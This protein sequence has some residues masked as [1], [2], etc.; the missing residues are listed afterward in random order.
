[1]TRWGLAVLAAVVAG[2]TGCSCGPTTVECSDV[3]VRFES[4]ANGAEVVSPFDVEIRASDTAGIAYK[5]DSATLTSDNFS[6]DGVV[7]DATAHFNGVQLPGGP[8]RL[9][10]TIVKGACTRTASIDVTVRTETCTTP[11]VTAVAFPQDTSND[12]ILNAAEL[13]A[14]TN[15]QVQVSAECTT[16]VE[17]QIKRGTTVVGGP[18]TFS[19]GVAT[20]TLPSLPDSDS[21]TYDLTAELLQ[22]GNPV[23]QPGAGSI[24]VERALPQCQNTT[25]QVQGPLQGGMGAMHPLLATGTTT[26]VAAEFRLDGAQVMTSTPSMGMVSATW[27]VPKSGETT[28]A[29][30]LRCTDNFGNV[31]TDT[32]MV[33]VDYLAPGVMITS[34]TANPDGGATTVTDSSVAVM[35]L[36]NAE[37]GSQVCMFRVQGAMRNMAGCGTVNG[38]TA[39]VPVDLP[40][41]GSYTL[42]VEVTDAAGNVGTGSVNIVA[43]LAG[44]GL[45]FTRPPACPALITAAQAPGG[46]YSFQT[47]SNVSCSAQVVR[48]SMQTLSADGG[49]IAMMPVGTGSVGS[50]G[51]ANIP[52]TVTSGEYIYI[53]ELDN[54]GADAGVSR[55]I[56]HVTVDLD[57]PVIQSPA[58][59]TGQPY[60]TINVA[61]DTQPATCGAQRLL[62]FSARVPT[63]G[64]A[65]LCTTQAVDPCTMATRSTSTAC[66]TGWY[67]MQAN[68]STPSSGFTF[69][70]GQYQIKLVVVG[71]GTTIESPPV[72]VLVDVTRPCVRKMMNPWPQDSAAPLGAL[73]IME[74][75]TSSP[76]LQFQLDPA[77]KDTDTTTLSATNPVVVRNIVSGT[78]TGAFNVAADATFAS[79]T[80]SVNLTQ[81]VAN[82]Q[83]YQFFVELTDIAGN[84]NLYTGAT[85]PARHDVRIDR[86]APSCDVIDPSA[87]QT[88]LGQAQVPGG[89]FTV[90]VGTSSDVPMNGISVTLAGPTTT[91]RTITPAAP[92]FQASTAFNLTGT[93]N[94][95]VSSTCT[96]VAGNPTAAMSRSLT[97][98]LDAPACTI[99]APTNTMPYSVNQIQ[100]TLNVTGAEGRL[101]TCTTNGTPLTPALLV[102]GGVATHLLTYPNGT[103]TVA[104]S[105]TDTAGNPGSCSVLGVVVNS[106]ACALNLTSTATT[107]S[108]FWHNRTNTGNLTAN[109]GTANVTANTPDCGAMKTVTLQRMVPT[110]G[111]PTSAMTDSMGN[112]SF[113]GVAIADGERWEVRIDNGAGVLTTQSFRVGLVAPTAS[114]VTIGG[115]AVTSGS[116]LNFVAATG[117]RNVETAAAG[118]FADTNAGANGAQLDTTVNAVTGAR[119]FGLDGTVQLVFKGT[120]VDSQSVTMEPQS[121]TFIGSTLPHND[122]GAFEVR[123]LDTAGN[124]TSVINN[125]AAIDVIAPGAPTV[126]QTLTNSRAA[127]VTLQWAPTYDDGMTMSSGGHAGY[128]VRWTT[129]SVPG[130]NSMATSTDYFASTSYQDTLSAWSA[131]NINRVLDLPPLNTYFI[132]VRAR[133]EVGNYSAFAAPTGLSNG[134]TQVTL[135]PI[136]GATFGQSVVTSSSLN[137]DT[138]E[139]LVVSAPTTPGGG[140]VYIFYGSAGFPSQAT[141]GAGCQQLVPSDTTAGQFGSD[142]GVGGNIGDVAGEGKPDLVVGQIWTS[143]GFGGRVVLF[144]GTSSGATVSTSNSIELRGDGT[145]RIG[146]T[147]RIIRD[148]DGDGLDEVAIAAPAFNSNQGRVFIYRGRTQA[149]WAAARTA[150]DGVTMVPY[151]PVSASTANY[152]ID[153]PSPILVTNGN[154][155]GQNRFGFTS[156]GDINSD[157][158]PDVAIPMSR[159]NINR[160]RIFSGAALAASTG[161]MPMSAATFLLEL[162]EPA[163]T[164]TAVNSGLG[165]SSV[166]GRD[167]VDSA[168]PDLVTSYNGAAGGGRVYVYSAPVAMGTGQPSPIATI[169]GPLTFGF[170]VSAGQ[171]NGGDTRADLVVGQGLS[172]DNVAWIVYQRVGSAFD[173]TG[174][175]SLGSSPAFWVSRF[176]GNVISGTTN[177]SLGKSNGVAD[178]DGN[179]Q[180]DVVLSDDRMGTVVIWR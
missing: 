79:G 57:G 45:G 67:V 15:L 170:Q 58:V 81:G 174:G 146:N 19:N 171:V 86:V 136:G 4:P 121:L 179:G 56:C 36:T 46:T 156:V 175:Q 55:A 42:E 172:T 142:L 104:C 90:T 91:T 126:T 59:P 32:R 83:D 149:Q 114:G 108:G 1:M 135:G 130:N 100:T 72:D 106:T 176:D 177:T 103:Q 12:G 35:V 26:G 10:A 54:L 9:T 69:T 29:V 74:L 38:G 2:L 73:N 80:Y 99:V 116:N 70:E 34:P 167:L 93:N 92:A 31:A 97:I 148:I 6:A 110:M 77:C 78:P 62:Q 165:A 43:V 107:A 13:P 88:L 82:E 24:R 134:W 127:Q 154:A 118:Y 95:T 66:G 128:D 150:T 48:L 161:A 160:Y 153:G 76:R 137:N 87:S 144:F 65:D 155:F 89:Q 140:A 51:Q 132:A 53:A 169:T 84:R 60:A 27:N 23:G 115:V 94:W 49:L 123:V 18:A 61:Q 39:A 41:D 163:G 119:K 133:D 44:C 75:G 141:C 147:A 105:L 40:M 162:S 158:T 152:V 129:S 28:Y 3:T 143:A 101:V 111:T 96:D 164:N 5:F 11:A 180:A 85:D 21:A 117:N 173:G 98:D 102:S 33:R 125:P 139:D 63:G 50:T 30:E 145:N 131:S 22:G 16:G 17:V 151:I 109:S 52:A 64:R 8:H 159:A 113:P 20:V 124:S 7:S 178:V 120:V 14:G 166:G 68:V 122:S 37:D 47:Q 25:V 157:T 71:G 138:I 112:V 168:A